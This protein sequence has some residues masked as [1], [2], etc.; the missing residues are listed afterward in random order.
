[1]ILFP[2]LSV[3]GG[4]VCRKFEMANSNLG[5]WWF[6]GF[7][8]ESVLEKIDYRICEKD[9][10]IFGTEG[11]HLAAALDRNQIRT[12][13]IVEGRAEENKFL[14]FESRRNGAYRDVAAVT[15]RKKRVDSASAMFSDPCAQV[16][17]SPVPIGNVITP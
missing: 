8:S 13:G 7:A 17:D 11:N 1:M 5:E 16:S 2:N 9:Q 12:I 14:H 4:G 6:Y 15:V 3:V 10:V